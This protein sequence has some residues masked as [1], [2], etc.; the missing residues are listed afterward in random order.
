MIHIA[1]KY[2]DGHGFKDMKFKL[3]YILNHTTHSC[4]SSNENGNKYMYGTIDI[5]GS[6]N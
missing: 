4:S 6:K 2:G 5:Y 3:K 1:F